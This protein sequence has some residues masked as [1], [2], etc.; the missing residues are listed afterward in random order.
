MKSNVIIKRY[1]DSFIEVLKDENKV[2]E[3]ADVITVK[4]AFNN[5]KEIYDYLNDPIISKEDKKYSIKDILLNKHSVFMDFLC[6]IID[7]DRTTEI[8]EI[9]DYLHDKHYELNNIEKVQV[10]SAQKISNALLNKLEQKLVK[11][12]GKKVELILLIDESIIG[13]LIIKMADTVT[14]MSIK[15]QLA[16]VLG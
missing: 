13:G 7:S 3:L 12:L 8:S 16:D 1:G 11:K 6:L 2:N 14:D 4:E 9:L 10:L 5:H 15:K